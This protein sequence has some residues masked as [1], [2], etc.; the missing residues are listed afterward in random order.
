M[1]SRTNKSL[2]KNVFK[3]LEIFRIKLFLII[4]SIF[5][6]KVKIIIEVKI[7]LNQFFLVILIFSYYSYSS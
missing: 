1:I 7:L 2:N 5:L 6:K 3:F 4:K